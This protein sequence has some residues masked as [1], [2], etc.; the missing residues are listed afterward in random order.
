M[1]AA[2]VIQSP[3]PA[4]TTNV[5]TVG[6]KYKSTHVVLREESSHNLKLILCGFR[7]GRQAMSSCNEI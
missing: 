6:T 2:A 4:W 5:I 7:S 1:G 3:S